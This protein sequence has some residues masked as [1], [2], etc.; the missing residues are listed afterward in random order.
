MAFAVGYGN[1]TAAIE[2]MLASMSEEELERLKEF[3]RE[4]LQHGITREE[5]KRL[6]LPAIVPPQPLEDFET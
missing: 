6:R 1:V 2:R 4:M 5:H 3:E